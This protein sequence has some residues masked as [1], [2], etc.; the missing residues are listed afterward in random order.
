M[1]IKAIIP[2]RLN[3]S[4]VSKKVLLPFGPNKDSLLLWKIKQLKK[5]LNNEDIIVSSE[6]DEL[7]EIAKKNN[8]SYHQR[9][10]YLSDAHKASFSEVITGIVS[11][12]DAQHIAW[13]TVVCPLMNSENY[14]ESFNAYNNNVVRKKQYDSL[15]GVNLVKEYLW[16]EDGPINYEANAN[17]IISQELPNIYKVTNSIYI[18]SK[19]NIL[20]N[21]YLIGS[22]P[23]LQLLP[24]YCG[25][26]IDTWFDYKLASSLLNINDENFNE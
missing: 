15:V 4:R 1:N 10:P 2:V 6:S 22:K 9:D 16:N 13:I 23:Y 7:L 25:I 19:E 18:S 17:H 26:D 14:K 8:V 11:E 12:I 24:N 21:K 5:I 20:Q 3:S